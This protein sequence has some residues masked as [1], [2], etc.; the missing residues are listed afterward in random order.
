M[1]GGEGGGGGCERGE[2]GG[3]VG[4]CE[5]GGVKHFSNTFSILYM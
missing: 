1:R 5:R 2:G 3:E 4:G